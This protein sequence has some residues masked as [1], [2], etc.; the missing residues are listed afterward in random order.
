[1]ESLG[2]AVGQGLRGVGALEE[3]EVVGVQLHPAFTGFLRLLEG[4]ADRAGN[5]V[6]GDGEIGDEFLRDLEGEGNHGGFA[7]VNRRG[8]RVA[9]RGE[10][11]V[12][13][14]DEFGALLEEL[15]AE[16]ALARDAAL[17]ERGFLAFREDARVHAGRRETERAQRSREAQGFRRGLVHGCFFPG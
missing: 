9:E 13:Q 14:F 1:M 11:A 2:R 6:G 5:G 4:F 12:L 15:L 8:Q 16:R 17:L 3:R 7:L 10:D